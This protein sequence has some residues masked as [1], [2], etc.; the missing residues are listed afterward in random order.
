MLHDVFISYAHLDNGPRFPGQQG[1]ISVFQGALKT[2]LTEKLGREV[3]LWW[4]QRDLSGARAFDQTIREACDQSALMVAIVSPRYVVSDSCHREIDYFWSR[5]AQSDGDQSSI[6]LVH[7]TP[8]AQ[9]ERIQVA[10]TALGDLLQR[11]LGYRFY[12]NDDIGRY[13]REL[14]IY[15]PDYGPTYQRALDDLAQDIARHLRRRF[16]SAPPSPTL[17]PPRASVIVPRSA[18]PSQVPS[19]PREQNELVFLAASATDV[20]PV[21]DAIQ[22][23]LQD[24]RLPQLAPSTW[25]DEY[26]GAVDELRT[27]A[28][29]A[30]ISV[31]VFGN[32]YGAIPDGSDRSKPEL[33]FDV[34]EQL[35]KERDDD[36]PLVRIVWLAPGVVPN[37]PRQ[38]AFVDR[39][40]AYDRW[41]PHDELLVGTRQALAERIVSKRQFLVSRRVARE[42]ERVERLTNLAMVNEDELVR[43][44]YVISQPADHDDAHRV[45]EALA[46][47]EWEVLSAAEVTDDA[48]NEAERERQHQE[49]LQRSDAFLI[50][51]GRSKFRW[52]RSQVDEARK[53]F[54]R[55]GKHQRRG[56]VYV[57]QPLTGR[58]ASYT[59]T[60]I[61][62]IDDATQ[63]VGL[64]LRQFLTALS[65]SP[66]RDM[67]LAK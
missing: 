22:L 19:G 32:D 33:H 34:V 53:A 15:D 4:D 35:A 59:L 50:Y 6:I 31:H 1:W 29:R 46:D 63:D 51:H 25:S 40:L 18:V 39:L 52:V 5:T 42:A 24:M 16:S 43:R 56:G 44:I 65:S 36:D 12:V 58:K 48:P 64:N 10:D 55:I 9:E 20:R 66:H 28:E 14:H 7:K 41:G 8:L 30:S 49:Y 57:A 17:V 38:Q 60:G 13:T 67:E 62:R 54:G 61:L 21:R 11:T 45:E 3:R 2:L 27:L 26:G 37:G 23:E 47:A